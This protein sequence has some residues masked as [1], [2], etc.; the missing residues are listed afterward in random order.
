MRTSKKC[1]DASNACTM[2]CEVCILD[3]VETGNKACILLCR[4]CADICN[5]VARFEARNSPFRKQLHDLCAAVCEA[6]AAEC[7][8][9]ASHHDSCKVCAAACKECAAICS[10]L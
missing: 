7:E 3:C 6:C 2:A 5:L 10:E 9:H 8:K 4:D 1:I